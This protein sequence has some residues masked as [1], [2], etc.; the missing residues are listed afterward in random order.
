MPF[1]LCVCVSMYIHTYIVTIF[2]FQGQMQKNKTMEWLSP[3]EDHPVISHIRKG[4][5]ILNLWYVGK[6]TLKRNSPLSLLWATTVMMMT[7]ILT[8]S[9]MF[10]IYKVLF[11]YIISD[12]FH[13][14]QHCQCYQP[15]FILIKKKTKQQKNKALRMHL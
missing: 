13:T 14:I 11:T 6:W 12:L 8:S 10:M 9:F 15:H 7:M 1:I 2:L 3:L 5:D 4:R